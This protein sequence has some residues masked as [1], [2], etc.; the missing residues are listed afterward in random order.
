MHEREWRE[1]S[2]M[3]SSL[4]SIGLVVVS[5]ALLRYWNLRHGALSATETQIVE[6]VMRLLQ[7]GSYHP[8]ALTQP[9]LPVYVHT[10][11]AVTHFMWGAIAGAWQSTSA[12]GAAQ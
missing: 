1:A 2:D 4:V 12:F 10:G 3:R 6:P 8:H 5:S 7:T 9:T 11:V